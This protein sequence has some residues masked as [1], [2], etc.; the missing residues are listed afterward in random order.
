MQPKFLAKVPKRVPQWQIA[1]ANST[2]AKDVPGGGRDHKNSS[3]KISLNLPAAKNDSQTEL[4]RFV[5]ILIMEQFSFTA[6]PLH[7]PADEQH[8]NLKADTLPD[9]VPIQFVI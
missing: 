1:N 7:R 4:L 6:P 3:H 9:R 2:P 5:S 8:G